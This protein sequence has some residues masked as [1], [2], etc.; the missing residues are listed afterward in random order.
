M[1]KTDF[2]GKDMALAMVE[3]SIRLVELARR[4][5]IN[6]TTLSLIKNGWLNPNPKQILRIRRVLRQKWM[7]SN[8]KGRKYE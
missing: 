1:V 4:T 2:N 7:V 3:K 5:D 8:K 6:K